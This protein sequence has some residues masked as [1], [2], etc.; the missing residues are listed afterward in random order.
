[1]KSL[2]PLVY[3]LIVLAASPALATSVPAPATLHV[4]PSAADPLAHSV[5]L[6][7]GV[8]NGAFDLVN[9][10]AT[11][12]PPGA[13]RNASLTGL[14]GGVPRP[15]GDPFTYINRMLFSDPEEVPGALGWM[16]IGDRQNNP[17]ELLFTTGPLT[18]TITTAGQVD[19]RL[20]LANLYL[21]PGG[22]AHVRVRLTTAGA[23]LSELT[24]LAGV[25]EPSAAGLITS[26]ALVG[27]VR[28]TRTRRGRSVA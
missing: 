22:A 1:M 16:L 19:N 11:A 24:T 10:Q 2:R 4:V 23:V 6:D 7:G 28:A 12:T 21:A 17:F 25:P 26:A 20:F 3:S 27:A 13:L 9:F 14:V 15:P 5:Y 18:G 8:L